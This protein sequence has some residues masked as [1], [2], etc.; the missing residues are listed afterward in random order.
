MATHSSTLA[1]KIPWAIIYG[2]KKSWTRLSFSL[3]TFKIKSL[4][5]NPVLPRSKNVLESTL[6]S[7]TFYMNTFIEARLMI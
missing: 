4:N 6:K 1:W 7:F 2:V 3:F 5:F